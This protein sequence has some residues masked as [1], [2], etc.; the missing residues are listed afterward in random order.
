MKKIIGIAA[1]ITL[2]SMLSAPAAYALDEIFMVSSLMPYDTTAGVETSLSERAGSPDTLQSYTRY[3]MGDRVPQ[4]LSYRN[5][6][7]SNDDSTNGPFRSA[8]LDFGFTSIASDL[9]ANKLSGAAQI[10][11]AALTNLATHE[12]GHVVVADSVGAEG[13]NM[14]FM[15]TNGGNFSLGSVSSTSMPDESRIS[16]AMGGE[17]FADYTFEY[18]LQSYRK[19]PSL[20]NRSVMFLSGTDLLR[21][22]IYAFYIAGPQEDLHDPVVFANEAGLS[23]E[24]VLG[25][26]IA[27]TMM[28]AYRIY[29][30]DDSFIPYFTTDRDSVTLNVKVRF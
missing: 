25:I 29:S 30:G 13:V 26:A 14:N 3:E 24:A 11:I 1:A 4:H 2:L 18:A 5:S 9:A 20:Y 15:Q 28:N 17:V 16:F 8:R 21:Y 6:R 12:L 22:T 23:R 10:G 7:L 19:R 27:K